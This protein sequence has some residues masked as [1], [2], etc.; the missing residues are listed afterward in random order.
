[1]KDKIKK[2]ARDLRQ[3]VKNIKHKIQKKENKKENKE[4]KENELS[5]VQLNLTEMRDKECIPIAMELLNI[6]ASQK[7][8]KGSAEMSA[9]FFVCEGK[10]FLGVLRRFT[11][12]FVRRVVLRMLFSRPAFFETA[13]S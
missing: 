2:I 9:L 10:R 12:G 13:A 7:D 11:G 4:N 6:L 8:L 1:M 5:P 3:R